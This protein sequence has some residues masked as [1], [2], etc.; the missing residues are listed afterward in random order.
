MLINTLLLILMKY[1]KLVEKKPTPLSTLYHDKIL[2]P[3]KT[4]QRIKRKKVIVCNSPI[5]IKIYLYKY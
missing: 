5:K 3:K 1:S 2:P 4:R